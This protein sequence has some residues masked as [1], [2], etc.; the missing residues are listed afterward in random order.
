MARENILSDLGSTLSVRF[1]RTS[2]TVK[3]KQGYQY[4]RDLSTDNVQVVLNVRWMFRSSLP[5][6]FKKCELSSCVQLEATDGTQY[7]DFRNVYKVKTFQSN[8]FY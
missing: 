6:V 8:W 7:G 2:Q 3:K 5:R 4:T 1:S